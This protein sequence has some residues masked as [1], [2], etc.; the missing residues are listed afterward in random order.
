MAA[1]AHG[2]TGTHI[3]GSSG[4]ASFDVPASVAANDIIVIPIFIDNASV[5]ISVMATGF[6]HAEN[7]P[8]TCANHSLAVVWKRA[9]GADA[10]TYD[11]TLSASTYRAGAA[12]RYTGA[13]TSGSPWDTPSDSAF[14]DTNDTTTPAVDVTTAGANRLLIFAGT[15]WAGGAWTPPTGFTERIDTGDRVHTLADKEQAVAGA[16]GSVQATNASSDKRCAWLGALAPAGLSAAIGI[17]SETDTAIA[18]GKQKNKA[19]GTATETQTALTL[20]RVKSRT[21][22]VAIEYDEALPLFDRSEHTY[23]VPPVREEG[24][25]V[26]YGLWKFYKREVGVSLLVSGSTVTEIQVPWQGDLENYDYFYQGGRRTPITSAE[27]AV[28][29]AAGYGAYIVHE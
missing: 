17:A 8:V 20:T 1:P 4:T 21:I 2:S 9:S 28:L 24:M 13:D 16:S 22:G 7:S 3:A 14:E 10:G 29:T 27:A 19:I 18:F 11:F 26:H 23:I 15:L 6:E 25:D 12:I 5:T